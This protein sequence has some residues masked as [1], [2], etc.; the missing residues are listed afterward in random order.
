LKVLRVRV[1]L[2]LSSH[3]RGRR[4]AALHLFAKQ[5]DTIK[6]FR[7]LDTFQHLRISIFL[8]QPLF[9][10]W[11]AFFFC[12]ILSRRVATSYIDHMRIYSLCR[13]YTCGDTYTW[14][15]ELTSQLSQALRGSPNCR[16]P[17]KFGAVYPRV[18]YF[19]PFIEMFS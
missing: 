4:E 19:R 8:C 3:K 15:R 6:T 1:G 12:F 11:K 13:K 5:L 2:K 7:Y 17:L 14:L 9:H 18:V 16:N 10:C